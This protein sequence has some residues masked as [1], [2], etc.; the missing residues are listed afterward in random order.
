MTNEAKDKK[1]TSK[2]SKTKTVEIC[3]VKTPV[4]PKGQSFVPKK[5]DYYHFDEQTRDIVMDINENANVL[6]TGHTGCGKTSTIRQIAARKNQGVLRV[7]LNG[8]TTIADFVGLWTVKSS[9]SGTDTVWIDGALPMALKKGYWLI[10]DEIDFAEPQILAVLNAVLEEGGEFTLKEKDG[11]VI[12]PHKNFRIF[13]TANTVGCMQDFRYLYQGANMVNEAFI[14]RWRVYKS[15]YLPPKEESKVLCDSIENMTSIISDKIV[16][17][18]NLVREAFEKEELNCT[19]SLRRLSDWARLMMR[20]K[21]PLK[22]AEAAIFSKVNSDDKD[23]IKGLITR[24][25][26]G[27]N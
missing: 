7:N 12:K 23:V 10:C 25:M 26:Y 14:D 5:I 19:F 20:S 16:E 11:E 4:I 1:S 15:D 24:V 21:D 22:A 18:G 13:G 27:E 9:S 3:G 6:L 8:Q 17:V 2:A